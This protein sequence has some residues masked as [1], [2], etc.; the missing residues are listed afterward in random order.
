[1]V[2]IAPDDASIA[3]SVLRSGRP[4][5]VENYDD[6]PGRLAANVRRFGV[7]SAVGA[8]IMVDGHLWGAMI[9]SSGDPE[10]LGPAAES[11][12]TAFTELVATAISNAEA[13]GEVR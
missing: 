8:P 5:R 6:A 9:A 2:R 4:A 3:A 7:R 10:P 1:E 11:K 13:R 12:I